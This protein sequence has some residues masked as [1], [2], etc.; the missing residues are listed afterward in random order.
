MVPTETQNTSTDILVENQGS[1]LLLRPLT[2][3]AREWVEEHIG[4]DNG[5]QPYWPTAVVEPRY[6][7]DI[8]FA[9]TSDGLVCR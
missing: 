5:Y 7:S 3:A 1:I 8:I 4:E 2:V 9:A 6:V